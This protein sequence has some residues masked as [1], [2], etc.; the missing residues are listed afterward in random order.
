MNDRRLDA[1]VAAENRKLIIEKGGYRPL[2]PGSKLPPAYRPRAA[3]DIDRRDIED[4]GKT[5]APQPAS[6]TN[7][8]NSPPRTP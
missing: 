8:T 3:Q 2:L 4:A 1:E 6:A 7:L 5:S